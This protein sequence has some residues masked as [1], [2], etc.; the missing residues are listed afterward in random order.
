MPAALTTGISTGVKIRIVGVMSIA[1]PTAITSTMMAISSSVWLPM[2]GCSSAIA[3][4]GMSA[5]VISHADTIAPAT[6][7]ITIA[8]V[9]AE[10]TKTAYTSRGFSS[11]ETKTATKSAR[12]KAAGD[13]A[14][15]SAGKRPAP[16]AK[17]RRGDALVIVESPAKARTI[18]K[19]LGSGFA[20]KA[21]VGHVRDLPTRKLGVDIDNGA[22][23]P[24]YVIIKGKNHTVAEI[25][26]AGAMSPWTY[27]GKYP[28]Y[29]WGIVF[30]MLVYYAGGDDVIKKLDNLEPNAWDDPAVK[31]ATEDLYQLWD[32]GYIM[33]GTA[34]LTH[35]ESQT[36]LHGHQCGAL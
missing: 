27:Q 15:K 6:R 1:V 17:P 32:K 34:G 33:P 20:V 29:I 7:N 21:T 2:N 23:T 9:V 14:P 22:F 26:K 16:K 5:T 30:N 12:A 18:G 25:K 28:Y 8:V 11:L 36:E 13:G 4:L 19:Y 35:T 31:R 3:L 10:L 24:E